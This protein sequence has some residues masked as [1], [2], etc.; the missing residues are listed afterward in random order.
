[1]STSREKM[2]GEVLS[3]LKDRSTWESRQT[4]FYKMRHNGVARKNKPYPNA[5]D[6]H[7]PLIDTNIEKLKPM[8]NQQIVGMDVVATFVP[9]RS[10]LAAFNTTAEQWFDYKIRERTNLQD[11]ALSWIDYM[12]TGGRGIIKIYWD[13]KKK[14]VCFDAFDPQYFIVPTHTKE[15]QDADWIVHVMPMSKAA[16]IRAGVYRSDKATIERIIGTGDDD[17]G[18]E[19]SKKKAARET[20]EGIT[21]S[22]DS[23]QVIVWEHYKHRDDGKWEI[24]TYSP[25]APDISL[26]DTR[27]LHYEHGE[28]PFVDAPYEIKDKGWYSPRGIAELLAPFES[29]LCHTWNQKHEFMQY[30]NK[31]LFQ[32]SRGVANTMNM[33]LSPGQILPAGITPVSMGQA[34]ISFDE[35][36]TQARSIAEQ[37]VANPDYGMGQV[38]N[39]TN[40]R[41]ATEIEAIAGQGAQAGDLRARTFRM[42]LGKL[43]K[44]AW[45]L[46]LQYDKEDLQYRYLDSSQQVDVQA[47]HDQYHIEPKG[48]VNEVN[49][50]MLLQKAISRKQIFANSP[51]INQPELDRSILELDDPSLIPRV[52]Q[53]P[54]QKGQ[55]EAADEQK[56]IPALMLGQQVAV[57]PSADYASRI[58]VV[59]QFINQ[60][61]QSGLQPPQ[62]SVG[63]VLARLAALVQGLTAQDNNAGKKAGTEIV[64]YLTSVGL[65]PQGIEQLAGAAMSRGQPQPVGSN[66][67]PQ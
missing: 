59:M 47:L 49:K 29:A 8:Y 30:V 64:K 51:W 66:S 25:A 10:Q 44:Q 50:T 15:L 65:A 20:R 60:M 4:T 53:D 9:M 31:P 38:T 5:P 57:P 48:G 3:S 62:Q 40:R 39:T 52:F 1:M 56:T 35:E 32:D 27:E 16:Y 34:P 13:V 58:S 36:L 21:H 17:K 12:L 24:H 46:L 28:A 41:T 45:A 22:K 26:R 7:W 42:R 23:E 63:A 61:V 6:L 11:E 43:Y 2:M 14:R 55:N 37:R 19:D 33:R 67:L 54:N 18:G